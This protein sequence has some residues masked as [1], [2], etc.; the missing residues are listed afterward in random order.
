[1]D[2]LD[3]GTDRNVCSTIKGQTH[4]LTLK[5]INCQSF[6]IIAAIGWP[7]ISPNPDG[8]YFLGGKVKR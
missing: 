8:I 7:V 6:R 4:R 1:M 3:N 2:L 5:C